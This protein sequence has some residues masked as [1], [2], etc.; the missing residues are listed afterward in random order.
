MPRQRNAGKGVAKERLISPEDDLSTQLR[1]LTFGSF[2]SPQF[3]SILEGK[4]NINSDLNSHE[5]LHT[6]SFG[7][8][9]MAQEARQLQFSEAG[10]STHL[11]LVEKLEIQKN[12]MTREVKYC[13][14]F[15]LARRVENWL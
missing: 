6:Q 10:T 9:T 15:H 7:P 11:T 1:S 2:I 12:R 13:H 4:E 14:V 5:S 8:P 3:Q